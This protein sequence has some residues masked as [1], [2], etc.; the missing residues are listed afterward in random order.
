VPKNMLWMAALWICVGCGGGEAATPAA[1]APPPLVDPAARAAVGAPAPDFALL[2]ADGAAVKLSDH[3]GKVVV[4]EWYN[5]DCPFVEYAHEKGP[6]EKLPAQLEGRG[7]VWLT[8]NSNTAG[9]QGAGA[10]RNR[11]AQGS[12]A[13]PRPVLM[14]PSGAVGRAY[15]ATVTPEV[16][17][18]D[19][20]GALVYRGGVDDAPLGKAP[21][22]A[23]IPFLVDAVDAVLAGGSP[24]QSQTKPYGCS[25]KYGA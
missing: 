17:V 11:R 14:D 19:A 7:V 6:L 13:L 1:P 15:G 25:V 5:P 3:R 8:L 21:G 10:D 12:H 20:A 4:V 23:P 9:A 22:D 16:F 2:N 18:I 24:K